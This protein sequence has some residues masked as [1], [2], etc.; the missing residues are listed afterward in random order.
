MVSG[1]DVFSSEDG[2]VWLSQWPGL[3]DVHGHHLHLISPL[4]VINH[5]IL[6]TG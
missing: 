6:K 5:M 2:R 1:G 3:K 4:S